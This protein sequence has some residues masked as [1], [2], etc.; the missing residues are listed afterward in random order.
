MSEYLYIDDKIKRYVYVGTIGELRALIH[1]R[2]VCDG[3]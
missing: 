2:V 1:E 3:T